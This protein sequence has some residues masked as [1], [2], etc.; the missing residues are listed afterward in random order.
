MTP[1]RLTT[2]PLDNASV[3]TATPLRYIFRTRARVQGRPAAFMRRTMSS[4]HW[5]LMVAALPCLTNAEVGTR[6]A[7]R[8]VVFLFRVPRSPFRVGWV[9]RWTGSPFVSYA[10]FMEPQDLKDRT[11]AFALRIIKVTEALPQTRTAD[12]IGRQLLR[13]GTSVGA[14]YRAARR[15][16]SPADFIHK[17][18][19][20]E[21]ESDESSYWLELLVDAGLVPLAKL[22]GLMKESDEI[23]AI[24]VASINTA[25]RTRK[26]ERGTRS[27]K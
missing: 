27:G 10:S 4:S 1:P 3:I 18:S 16:K 13:C 17:M 7:E 8:K 15:A 19:I 22:G 20:V 6:N 11:K 25:K 26:S 21:E 2:V 14:N 9:P 23:T 12:V 24:V 5:S